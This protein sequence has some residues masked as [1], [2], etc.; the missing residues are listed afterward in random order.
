MSIAHGRECASTVGSCKSHE[1]MEV[2]Y[3][4]ISRYI[5]YVVECFKQYIDNE[6]YLQ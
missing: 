3:N 4:S 5:S 1:E 6:E 2:L